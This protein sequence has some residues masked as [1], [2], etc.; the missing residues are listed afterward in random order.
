MIPPGWTLKETRRWMAREAAAYGEKFVEL[1]PTTRPPDSVFRRALRNRHFLVQE[2]GPEPHQ[3]DHV[4]VRLS[5]NRAV[6]DDR[7]GWL[8]GI[9]WDELQRIKAAVG[10]GDHDALEVYPRDSKL[11]NVANIR[12]L[13]VMREQPLSW[14]WGADE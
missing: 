7:G 3:V 4:L 2:Y 10:Y 6:L 14:T 12:H 13:W 1:Q 5:I 11:V 9:T 8:D